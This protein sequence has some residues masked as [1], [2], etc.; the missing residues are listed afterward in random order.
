MN[1]DVL[2][3]ERAEPKPS[4]PTYSTPMGMVASWL[5]IFGVEGLEVRP[6]G[7][8]GT[9][10]VDRML[11]WSEFAA[12]MRAHI[13]RFYGSRRAFAIKVDANR[14]GREVLIHAYERVPRNKSEKSQI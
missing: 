11:G 1:V 13:Q 6:E 3:P 8:Y 7:L 14:V 12:A 5:T 9:L 10:R 4:R 2:I